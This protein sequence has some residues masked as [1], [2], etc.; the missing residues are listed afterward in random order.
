MH[1]T[2]VNSLLLAVFAALTTAAPAD[3]VRDVAAPLIT[4]P[5]T[6]TGK[7]TKSCYTFTAT[8]TPKVCP[9]IKCI[10]D[11]PLVC[12]M[13]VKVT[14]TAVPCAT[15]CCPVTPTKYTTTACP[16]CATGCVIP[17][18]TETITTGCKATTTPTAGPSVTF[19]TGGSSTAT[20]AP[21]KK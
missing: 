15:N 19:I 6:C 17:T 11:D 5:A 8:T 3:L 14:T 13:I 20:L 9:M 16:T 2:T 7:A 1:L 4:L 10:G 12:P 18:I 21:G